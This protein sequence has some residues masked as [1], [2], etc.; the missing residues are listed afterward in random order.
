MVDCHLLVLIGGGEFSFGETNEIDRFLLANLPADRRKVAFLP[1]ASGSAEYATHLG[2]HFQELDSDVKTLNV[3]IYRTRDARRRRNIEMLADAGMIY[4]GGGVTNN[5]LATLR[6]SPA[7][8]AL[9][10]ASI[11]GAVIA[12]I[13]AGASCFG[14]YARDMR[15]EAGSLHALGWV[16]AAVVEAPF[17]PANDG[18]LRRLMSMPVNVGVGIP[19]R[20][21]VVLRRAAAAEIIGDGNIAIFRKE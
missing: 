8:A 20:T 4:I 9:R 11:G 7:E 17:D 15:G 10:E 12:A 16:S 14:E 2:K 13:G 19:P 5:V 3:P 18:S 21:A 6:E 1:T